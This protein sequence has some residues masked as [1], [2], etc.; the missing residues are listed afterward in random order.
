MGQNVKRVLRLR[1]KFGTGKRM[2]IQKLDVKNTFRKCEWTQPRQQTSGT[3]GEHV[4]L[5]TC[6]CSSGGRGAQGGGK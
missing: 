2:L 3:G 4:C 1:D 6:G 5:L